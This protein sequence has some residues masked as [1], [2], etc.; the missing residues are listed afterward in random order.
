MEWVSKKEVKNMCKN[1]IEAIVYDIILCYMGIDN[2]SNELLLEEDLNIDSINLIAIISE[3]ENRIDIEI[4]LEELLEEEELT[5]GTLIN[6]IE[7]LVR[8]TV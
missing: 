2:V 1:Q 4:E 8:D 3:I 5:V 7:F 6:Y